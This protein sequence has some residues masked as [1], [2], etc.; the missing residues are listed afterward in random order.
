[1]ALDFN[2]AL[3]TILGHVSL[4]LSNMDLAHPF[5]TAMLEVEKAAEKAAEVSQQL[6]SFSRQEKVARESPSSQS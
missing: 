1:M 3:T 2:N 6:A 5:R 4:V